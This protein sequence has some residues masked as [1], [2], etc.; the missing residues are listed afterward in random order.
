MT[1]PLNHA[2][3][4]LIANVVFGI[5]II[6]YIKNSSHFSQPVLIVIYVVTKMEKSLFMKH[7]V[8]FCCVSVKGYKEL[9]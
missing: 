6:E 7:S 2:M 9:F 8:S 5:Y 4:S 1:L 3:I